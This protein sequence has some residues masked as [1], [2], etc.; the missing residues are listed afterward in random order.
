MELNYNIH[1]LN[2]III[3]HVLWV[4]LIKYYCAALEIVGYLN[5]P[6]MQTSHVCTCALV[7]QQVIY[8]KNKRVISAFSHSYHRQLDYWAVYITPYISR[9]KSPNP[10]QPL[11]QAENCAHIILYYSF[12][13]IAV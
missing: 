12:M 5:P 6:A 10:K 9:F 7:H 2:L 13:M 4:E 8:C 11:S 3:I 1:E